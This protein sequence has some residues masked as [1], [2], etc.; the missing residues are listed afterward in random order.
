L[1]IFAPRR[2]DFE[3][4]GL[5]SATTDPTADPPSEAQSLQP[6]FQEAVDSA[7]RILGD[8]GR[9][10]VNQ[11]VK[12]VDDPPSD[13]RGYLKEVARIKQVDPTALT[14]VVSAFLHRA[15]AADQFV[16]EPDRLHLRPPS[17]G[18][19]VCPRCRQRHLH[20]SAGIC[21]D[22]H[23]ELPAQ[24]TPATEI[25]DYYAFLASSAGAPFRLHSEE[26]TGQTDYDDAQARQ[27]LFQGVFL[28]GRE[29]PLVDEI[30]LLSVTTTMEVGVDIGDLRAVL[31]GNMPPMRFNYQQRVGR[32]GRRNDP[33]AAALTVCRGRSHDDYYFLNPGRITGEPP[34]VPY[35]DM[36][37][38]EIAKRSMLSE[39]LRQ[40]FRA[41]TGKHTG[42]EAGDNIHGQFGTANSWTGARDHIEHWL[43]SHPGEVAN[44]VDGFLAGADDELKDKRDELVGYLR[45]GFLTQVDEFANDEN[46][47]ATD[48][49]QRLAEA[50]LLP[51]F[52]F[53]TRVR[54]LYHSFPPDRANPWPPKHVIDRDASIAISQWSPG[55]EVVKDKGIHRCIGV[56]SYY[57]KG[58]MVVSDPD[59]LGPRRQLGHCSVCGTIDATPGNHETCPV[60]GAPPRDPENRLGGYRS[61]ELVLKQAHGC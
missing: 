19:W 4:T 40:A 17:G 50:G 33:L 49:S 41:V 15:G 25:R 29:I 60:C 38:P 46:L 27:A 52:G 9:T 1:L 51:M 26:L 34:P 45:G 20:P 53:P 8:L 54:L 2:R 39:V 12:G 55:S 13:L 7:L 28:A 30:D 14:A 24:A 56:A 31:V 44:L 42:V 48:L 58:N 5:G 16:L 32:A 35:L 22:C 21:A 59:P 36:R 3:S 23:G 10:S 6:W 47:P 18:V 57:P 43:M 11:W 37:R 61:L